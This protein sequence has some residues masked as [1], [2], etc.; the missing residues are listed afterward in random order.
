MIDEGKVTIVRQYLVGEFPS[1][2]IREWYDSGREAQCFKIGSGGT[3]R[4]VIFAGEFLRH[5]GENEIPKLLK[6]FLLVEH[7]RECDLPIIVT[8]EGLSTE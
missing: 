6:I 5:Y 8:S 7:L 3:C 2:E 4:E 1:S